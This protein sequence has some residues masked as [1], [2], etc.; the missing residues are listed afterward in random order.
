MN[1][2]GVSNYSNNQ[3][4]NFCSGKIELYSDF[5]K[6]Y[7]PLSHSQMKYVTPQIHPDFAKYCKK[8]SDFRNQ[9]KDCLTFHLT[10]GRTLGET[11][12]IY[13]LIKNQGFRL[14]LPDTLIV[15]NGSDEHL[16]TGS[17]TDFYEKGVFSFS[18]FVRNITY[19]SNLRI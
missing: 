11:D 10:T 12:A 7:F 3:V 8:F 18:C 15:K 9:M 5:D 1:I 16:K 17:D 19:C 6:T 2:S 14:P 4:L 13:H